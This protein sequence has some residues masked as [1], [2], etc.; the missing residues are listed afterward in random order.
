[1]QP[2]RPEAESHLLFCGLQTQQLGLSRPTL[3]ISP[4]EYTR[5]NLRLEIPNFLQGHA[6]LRAL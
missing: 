4:Q 3:A 2:L 5:N 1:M 6:V